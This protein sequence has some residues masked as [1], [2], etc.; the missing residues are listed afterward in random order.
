MIQESASTLVPPRPN[1][2]PE[3]WSELSA[4]WQLPLV[5]GLVSTGL[6]LCAFWF[7]RQRRQETQG[8][9]PQAQP[10]LR[11]IHRPPSSCT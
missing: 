7:L 8:N 1:P 6:L 11:T 3:P 10:V 4:S 2:G 9:H 5:A